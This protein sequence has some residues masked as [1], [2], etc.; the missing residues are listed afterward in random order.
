VA[1]V[2]ARY[3]KDGESLTY[4]V[5]IDNQNIATCTKDEKALVFKGVAVGATTAT[6]TASNG[7]KHSFNITVRKSANNNGWL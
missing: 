1:F 2:P 5:E 3:F 7:V 4:S 6:I